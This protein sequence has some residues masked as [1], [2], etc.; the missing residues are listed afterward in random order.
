MSPVLPSLVIGLPLVKWRW[1]I[2]SVS[3]LGDL[4]GSVIGTI[5]SP[6][7]ILIP[8]FPTLGKSLPSQVYQCFTRVIQCFF[9]T[10][11]T[12]ASAD[13]S[14][15]FCVCLV[16]GRQSLTKAILEEGPLKS[17]QQYVFTHFPVI[18]LALV[19]VVHVLGLKVT[20]SCFHM[21]M[22]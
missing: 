2:M 10:T 12:V 8:L 21:A 1:L 3:N 17:M 20:K 18:V 16:F 6:L 15:L 5:N 7:Q 19:L 9:V 4:Q 11:L 22:L 13:W 14:S